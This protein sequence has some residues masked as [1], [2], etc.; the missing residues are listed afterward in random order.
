[1]AIYS[2]VIAP[3]QPMS[4]YHAHAQLSGPWVSLLVGTPLF[5]LLARWIGLRHRDRAVATALAFAALYLLTD[6]LILFVAASSIPWGMVALNYLAK[7]T[8]AFV[9]GWLATKE[10]LASG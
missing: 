8:A 10:R 9:G 4:A 2:H 5:V 3:D 1:V 7:P 6:A